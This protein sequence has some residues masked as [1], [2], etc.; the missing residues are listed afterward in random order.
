MSVYA[1]ALISE[2]QLQK[3]YLQGAEVSTLYF[4]G[5]TPSLL[6][7]AG[8]RR[9]IQAAGELFP[10]TGQPEIT[11]EANPDDINKVYLDDILHCGV[12]RISLGIQSFH[13]A[14]LEYLGRIHTGEQAR[15]AIETVVQSGIENISADLIYGIPTLTDDLWL[16]NLEMLVV[17]RIPHISAYALTMEE[18]TPLWKFVADG[19]KAAPAEEQA[20]RHFEMLMDFMEKHGY[21][22]YEISNFCLPGWHSRH[23]MSYWK[24]EPYLGLGASAH[25]FDGISRQWNG[26]SVSQYLKAVGE[27][28]IPCEK[29]TLTED[30]RCNEYMMTGLRTSDGVSLSIIREQF[31]S[32]R[33]TEFKTLSKEFIDCGW[34]ENRGVMYTLTRKG[35][36]FADRVAAHLFI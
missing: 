22:H 9:M 17:Y 13:D 10:L 30:D 26:S 15:H 35:K 25:S 29:E 4:G 1:D 16:E 18:K 34:M 14:D 20:A 24:G 21:I 12:N 7:A 11:L 3:D 33:E 8:I 32:G 27:G 36:L 23:N 19:T 6:A 28:T 2:M 31:G 5:G